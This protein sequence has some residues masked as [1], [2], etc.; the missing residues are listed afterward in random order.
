VGLVVDFL[1]E[2]FSLVVVSYFILLVVNFLVVPVVLILSLLS[3][4]VS[5]LRAFVVVARVV[6]VRL[7][8]SKHILISVLVVGL[9]F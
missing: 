4:V 7:A 5:I 6:E 9:I 1:F 3:V 8:L 2:V